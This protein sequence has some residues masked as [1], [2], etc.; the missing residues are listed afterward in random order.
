MIL[1]SGRPAAEWEAFWVLSCLVLVWSRLVTAVWVL[2]NP[3]VVWSGHAWCLLAF[4]Y[5]WL[6]LIIAQVRWIVLLEGERPRSS[7]VWGQVL[8]NS[9]VPGKSWHWCY[10]G[11]C[12]RRS[13][14]NRVV[15]A[16]PDLKTSK[17]ILDFRR[18]SYSYGIRL[19]VYYSYVI[20]RLAMI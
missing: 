12:V 10:T 4:P 17:E 1:Q 16:R 20:I 7:G 9:H 13:L 15:A 18:R 3:A 6:R 11:R 8:L 19:M 2:L 14:R 5:L